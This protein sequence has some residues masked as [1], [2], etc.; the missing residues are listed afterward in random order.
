MHASTQIN[1]SNIEA[2]K[3]YAA[4][5]DVIVLAH[6][7]NPEQVKEIHNA[8]IEQKIKGP[9]GNLV[10]LEIFVHG[11]LCMAVSGK[12]YLSLHEKN[13]SANRGSV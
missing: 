4:F 9:S 3:F 13:Y 10:K 1:V 5:C 2:L 7:L 6:E 8:I 11:A 12:C